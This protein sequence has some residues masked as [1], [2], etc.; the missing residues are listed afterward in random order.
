CASALVG[1][2]ALPDFIPL[3]GSGQSSPETAAVATPVASAPAQ[4][5]AQTVS[6]IPADTAPIFGVLPNGMRYAVMHNATPPGQASLRLHIAAGSLMEQDGQRGLAHFLEHMAFNGTTR[7]PE[8]EL[9]PI[10][11]RLG[12]A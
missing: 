3:P 4:R 7:V 9:L 1:C 6:D 8:G 2:A 5:W 10:L 12:L 11:E